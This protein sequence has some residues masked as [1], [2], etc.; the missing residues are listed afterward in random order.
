MTANNFNLIPFEWRILSLSAHRDPVEWT[1]SGIDVMITIFCDFR[2]FWAIFGDFLRFSAIYGD[3]RRF[4]AIFGDFR[5]KNARFLIN[6]CHDPI[7]AQFSL[8]LSQKRQFFVKI[9]LKS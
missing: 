9:F 3:F 1:Q 2:R 4:S 5:R 6:Q 8:A 7:T